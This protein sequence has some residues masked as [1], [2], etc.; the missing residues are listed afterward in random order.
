MSRS[1][2]LRAGRSSAGREGVSGVAL[3]NRML[4]NSCSWKREW[5]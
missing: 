4:W 5:R 3:F 2:S 1:P